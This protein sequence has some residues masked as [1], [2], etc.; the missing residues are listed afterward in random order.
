MHNRKHSQKIYKMKGCSKSRKRSSTRS[1]SRSK[2][3][4]RMSSKAI[5]KYRSQNQSI[6]RGRGIGRGIGIAGGSC[7]SCSVMQG[8][9]VSPFIGA[10]WSVTNDESQS[11]GNYYS[12][13]LYKSADPQTM[14]KLKGGQVIGGQVIGGQVIGGQKSRR[15][16]LKGGSLTNFLPSDLVNLGRDFT[17]NVNSA[18]SSL[19]GAPQPVNPSPVE[20]HLSASVNANRIII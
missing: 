4:G 11:T 14:M 16:S 19:T 8:G 3:R 7:S 15:R 5:A 6:G 12:Q 13:N 9:S 10:P 2:G 20:G 18:Y 1:K 17:Y